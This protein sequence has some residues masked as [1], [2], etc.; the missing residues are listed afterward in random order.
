[1]K[2]DLQELRVKCPLP[3][4]M[5]KVGLGRFAKS[6][7]PSPFRPDTHASWGIFQHNGRWRFKDFATGECGDEISFLAQYHALDNTRDFLKLLDRYQEWAVGTGGEQQTGMPAQSPAAQLPDQSF[8]KHG[9]DAQ[10]QNLSKLRNI[11]MAGLKFAADKGNLKF[12]TW[13]S[14]EVYAV[15]DPSGLLVELRRLDGQWFDGSGPMPA[16][17]SH[18]LKHG[19]KNWPLGILGA[20]DC[21]GLALAEGMPDFL[22]LHQFVVEEGMAGKI[23][24]IAMLTGACD[25]AAQALPHF[26]GKN[27][28]IFPHQDGPGID[29]A[30]RWQTQLVNAGV[31]H[32]D[33]FNFK[34]CE[35][36]AVKIK[37]L[38]DFNQPG[39][40]AGIQPTKLLETLAP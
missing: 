7:C 15:T 4:L 40:A 24:P 10:L 12:G 17:K 28:R 30:E 37:D 31:K 29:A 23:A 39:G 27:V 35:V 20:K 13:R 21:A 38:C 36:G 9:T 22:A 34:A 32:L 26:A 25:I 8:L 6:S 11:R 18:T 2:P 33:F 19:R 5:S 16:H 3:V 14:H 1:M